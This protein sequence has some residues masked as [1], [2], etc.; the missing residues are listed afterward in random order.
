MMTTEGI[1]LTEEVHLCVDIVIL[2][3]KHQ[4]RHLVDALIQS[5]LH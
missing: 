5:D 2:I 4:F 1:H 3:S